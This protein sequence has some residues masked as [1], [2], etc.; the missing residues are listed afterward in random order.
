MQFARVYR[1]KTLFYFLPLLLN[2]GFG[3]VKLM[4]PC[5]G[6]ISLLV[7]PLST[8]VKREVEE[9]ILGCDET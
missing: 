9:E 2:R 7:T 8:I 4:V 5:W 1:Y 6:E 3:E